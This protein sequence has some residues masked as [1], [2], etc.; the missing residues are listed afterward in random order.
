MVKLEDAV[1]ARYTYQGNRFELLVDPRLAMELRKGKEVDFEE[2]LAVDEVFKDALRG[3]RQSES[4]VKEAFGTE[5][6]KEIAKRI[7]AKGELQLTTEQRREL[8]EKKKK[9]IIQIICKNAYNPQ[10]N[11]PHPPARIENA[12]EELKINIHEFEPADEQAARILKELKRILPIALDK[13]EIAIKVPAMH[14]GRAS[15]MLH[16][17]EIKKQEWQNDG[18]LIVLLEVPAGLKAELIDRVSKLT[19]GEAEVK[20]LNKEA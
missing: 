4:L 16:E 6:I 9:E 12:L 11:A 17:Y 19:H 18:S 7:I 3:E 10:T 13:F 8:R 14:A 5:D 1:V 15:A 2:L 20:I